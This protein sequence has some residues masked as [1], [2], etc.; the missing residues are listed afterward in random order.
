ML[1]SLIII[2]LLILGIYL[3]LQTPSFGKMPAG[4]R[5]DDIKRSANYRDG[6][7]QNLSETP[8]LTDGAGY[9]TV[10]N[11]FLFKKKIKMENL[12]KYYLL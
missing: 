10:L 8:D 12:G 9:F 2:V 7:F 5:L 4:K 1:I 3:F 6:S 11:E